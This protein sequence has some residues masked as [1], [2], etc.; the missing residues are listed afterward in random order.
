[1]ASP[2]TCWAA[3]WPLTCPWHAPGLSQPT[4]WPFV[5]PFNKGLLH[6]TTFETQVWVLILGGW[7]SHGQHSPQVSLEY[8]DLTLDN[9][10]VLGGFVSARNG[11]NMISQCMA[12]FCYPCRQPCPQTG[13]SLIDSFGRWLIPRLPQLSVLYPT[14]Y[15]LCCFAFKNFLIGGGA[16]DDWK[17]LLKPKH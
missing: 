11:R 2:F 5:F 9:C 1:M 4:L 12:C 17:S 15:W 3:S 10:G 8:R 6:I 16:F 13:A 7:E 14:A